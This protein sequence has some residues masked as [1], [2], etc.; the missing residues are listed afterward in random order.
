MSAYCEKYSNKNILR[1][2]GKI[3]K[4]SEL[5]GDVSEVQPP[6]LYFFKK[7]G[8]ILTKKP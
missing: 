7:E 1:N 2:A 5:V 4:S 3:S 8:G 6:P